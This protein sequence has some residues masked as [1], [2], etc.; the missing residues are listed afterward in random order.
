MSHLKLW[1]LEKAALE[2]IDSQP[3]PGQEDS[4]RA[5]LRPQQKQ[6]RAEEGKAG[7]MQLQ[8]QTEMLT[9]QLLK[10]KQRQEDTEE[11]AHERAPLLSP[12]AG[13]PQASPKGGRR[14]SRDS[15]VSRSPRSGIAGSTRGGFGV[16]A[17]PANSPVAGPK[18]LKESSPQPAARCV[19]TSTD[20]L[21]RTYGGG[22]SGDK[23]LACALDMVPSRQLLGLG[24]SDAI[25]PY[26]PSP[27][28]PEL[29]SD[30]LVPQ[31][32]EE[33]A[34]AGAPLSHILGSLSHAADEEC[35]KLLHDQLATMHQ[36]VQ[37]FA[38]RSC[39]TRP[40]RNGSGPPGLVQ[41]RRFK[42]SLPAQ[43]GGRPAGQAGSFEPPRL[44]RVPTLPVQSTQRC[45]S[46]TSLQ[47]Q[48]SWHSPRTPITPH[49][50]VEP[51]LAPAP[52][53][54]PGLQRQAPEQELQWQHSDED[55][56]VTLVMKPEPVTVT[57]KIIPDEPE[58]T[59]QEPELSGTLPNFM[60][61]PVTP[62]PPA[63]QTLP[64]PRPPLPPDPAPVPVPRKVERFIPVQ[65]PSVTTTR[66]LP[67]QRAVSATPQRP[68]IISCVGPPLAP[69]GERG[70]PAGIVGQPL[71]MLRASSAGRVGCITTPAVTPP[72]STP[73]SSH[74]V[75]S[76]PPNFRPPQVMQV[77]QVAPLTPRSDS[78][79]SRP[80]S[81]PNL[82]VGPYVGGTC[83]S[84]PMQAGPL[85]PYGG[86]M[87]AIPSPRG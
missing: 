11:A 87:H 50:P 24:D 58:E 27:P 33:I 75:P 41:D 74:R 62:S 73:R 67:V 52:A 2:T 51:T 59:T 64:G 38:K 35:W 43:A 19:P 26:V 79:P 8:H 49:F 20:P 55:S 7:D 68:C 66:F 71:Q 13:T 82:A 37:E 1:C 36:G 57:E 25:P 30:P 39:P 76:T 48:T 60:P 40:M 72:F 42:L 23:G 10:L 28:K 44:L 46:R 34:G 53:T 15:S 77:P 4:P 81:N 3:S 5:A 61:G 83:V 78:R 63:M 69:P 18:S 85:Q 14:L 21:Q 12:P 29:R 56:K 70:R 6:A 54:Q 47:R 16:P 86:Q 65:V 32:T 22:L 80:T 45:P 84:G 9:Q 31:S 17:P